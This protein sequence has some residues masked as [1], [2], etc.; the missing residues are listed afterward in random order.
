MDNRFLQEMVLDELDFDPRID[1]ANIGVV[2]N[3]GVVT[4]SG[5]VA[6]FAEK[7][8]A[9][10][11]ARRVKGV[12]AVAQEIEVRYPSDKK[13][14][15][16][17]IAKRALSVIKWNTTIPQDTIQMT[18]QKGLVTLSGQ[19]TWQY[20]RG[21]AEQS[22]R[23]LSGVIGVINNIEI[24]PVTTTADIKRRIEKALT[25]RAKLEASA[26]RVN[27]TDGSMVTLEGKVDCWDERQAVEQAAWS[28]A[29]VR[30]VDDQLTI[31]R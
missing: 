5:H 19:V 24:K 6:S 1:A 3:D 7:H 21:D 13:T 10:E 23:K 16:D 26:I 25:R 2:A 22:V 30:S 27:V 12:H 11:V 31:V 4:L 28:V 29:G 8:A 20:Q 15:D 9:E 14:S 17:E 18:V